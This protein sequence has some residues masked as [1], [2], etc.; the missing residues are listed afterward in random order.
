MPDQPTHRADTPPLTETE[1]VVMTAVLTA[2]SAVVAVAVAFGLPITDGQQDAILAALAAVAPLVVIVSRRWTTPT[3][4]VV[5][6]TEPQPVGPDLVVAGEASELPTGTTIRVAGSL[7][8][9]TGHT[10]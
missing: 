9:V 7:D 8:P 3:A 6:Q 1:P 2:A 4:R 10:A 5:E